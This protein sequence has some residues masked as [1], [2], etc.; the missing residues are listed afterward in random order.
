MT[1]VAVALRRYQE[2]TG[3][4]RGP[5]CSIVDSGGI[6]ARRFAIRGTGTVRRDVSGLDGT[7]LG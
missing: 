7:F 3:F 5:P 6:W 1:L 2:M 4:R